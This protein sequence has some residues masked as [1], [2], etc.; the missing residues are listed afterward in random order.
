[1]HT[2]QLASV[3]QTFRVRL[4][5]LNLEGVQEALLKAS[6]A[7]T[8]ATD[9]ERRRD[10]AVKEEAASRDRLEKTEASHKEHLA[11]L[12][13]QS[14][15][16]LKDAQVSLDRVLVNIPAAEASIRDIG[17]RGRQIEVSLKASADT[18]R[19]EI[20]ALKSQRDGLKAGLDKLKQEAIT[21]A[22]Q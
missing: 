6:Q 22:G 11:G 12:D 7:E 4:N 3:I 17:E 20:A 9:A 5:E 16:R 21:L 10:L 8:L 15:A 19:D 18:L 2:E 14:T 13:K 1:M